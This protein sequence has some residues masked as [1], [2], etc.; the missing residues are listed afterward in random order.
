MFLPPPAVKT[1]RDLIYWQYA[2]IIAHSAGMGKRNYRFVMKKYLELRSGEIF[3]NSVREYVKEMERAD[4][5]IYCGSKASLTLEHLFPRRL[6]GPDDEK[7]LV[8]VCKRCNSAKGGRRLYEYWTVR[9]G[10]DS[11]KYQIPRIAEG[12]YLKFLYELFEEKGFLDY[13]IEDIVEGVCPIC[14][15][16]NLCIENRSKHRLS[17]LCLDGIATLCLRER[18]N[19]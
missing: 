5:C 15:L 19:M 9:E 18:P 8:R 17:P 2:K 14:D 10:L 6:G 13:R 1:V 12:K 11:A 7:N 16:T 3:W 4:Q